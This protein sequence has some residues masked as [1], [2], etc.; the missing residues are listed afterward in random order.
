MIQIFHILALSHPGF[1]RHQLCPLLFG[2]A[3]RPE[4]AFAERRLNR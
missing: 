3:C 2:E 4:R 1:V